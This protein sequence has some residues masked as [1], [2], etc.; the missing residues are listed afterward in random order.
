MK[1]EMT[2]FDADNDQL[3]YTVDG[4]ERRMYEDDAYT[5]YHHLIVEPK[6]PC[7]LTQEQKA[8]ARIYEKVVNDKHCTCFAFIGYSIE[9]DSDGIP[10]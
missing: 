3:I 8:V 4:E 1:I 2:G 7:V 10:V 5:A 9:V 6:T